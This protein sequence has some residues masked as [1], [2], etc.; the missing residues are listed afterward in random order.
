VTDLNETDGRQILNS[1]SRGDNARTDLRGEI[2]GRR[3]FAAGFD[4]PLHDEV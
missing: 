2:L 1:L 3:Q 4:L